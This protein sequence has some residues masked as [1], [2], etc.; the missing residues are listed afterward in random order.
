MYP[1]K[2]RFRRWRHNMRS[3]SVAFFRRRRARCIAVDY[4]RDRYLN[5][6][7]CLEPLKDFPSPQSSPPQRG[8]AE[9]GATACRALLVFSSQAG[10]EADQASAGFIAA[11][12]GFASSF[13]KGEDEAE[14]LF[15][16][17]VTKSPVATAVIVRNILSFS[18]R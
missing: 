6:R 13:V 10:G 12:V 3:Q 17:M 1:A 15:S 18:E 11:L 7:I 5:S 8:E 14:G 2:L 16:Q 9:L 4:R